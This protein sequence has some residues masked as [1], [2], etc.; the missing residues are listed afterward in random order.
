MTRHLR[1][2]LV[3][4]GLTALVWF[5]MAMSERREYP[6]NVRVDMTGYDE[7]RYAVVEADTSVTL[8]V[9]SNGFNMFVLSLRREPLTLQ[10]D[11][12]GDAVRQSTHR[13]GERT[14]WVRSVAVADLGEA[15]RRQ[16]STYNIKQTG[17]IK[18]SL[19]LVLTERS[20]RVFKPDISAV[21]ITFADGYGLYGEPTLTP[22]EVVIYGSE[23]TLNQIDTLKI[24]PTAISGVAESGRYR[25]FLDPHWKEAGD[26]YASTEMFQLYVP[27]ES[28]VERR[29]EIPV[30][31][32]G[33]D[34]SVRLRLYPGKVTLNL[35]VAQRDLP[36]VSPER[37]AV[38]ADYRDV[39]AGEDRLKL[40]LSRFPEMVRMR[41]IIPSE[42][43]YVIIK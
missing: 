14:Q 10:L 21:N 16:L 15:F 29:Y 19:L 13:V 11:M 35:W 1:A 30:T 5:A 2:F 42:V 27:V 4:L 38:T 43:Q 7:R 33:A 40:R 18:D 23:E 24:A 36:S 34:T 25:L 22:S 6:L 26:L 17:S 37:F 9:E 39:L 32:V 31:V 28:Y 12:R 8:Q 20:S 41:N 3:I